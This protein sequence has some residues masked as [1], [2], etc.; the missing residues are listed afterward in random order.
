MLTLYRRALA[1]RRGSPALGRGRLHWVSPAEAADQVLSFDL[2]GGGATVR[3]VVNVGS[4]PVGLPVGEVLLASEATVA[5]TLPP[6]ATAWIQCGS[7][8]ATVPGGTARGS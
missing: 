8:S 5:G 3:V 1:V 4:D 7:G 6:A 2:Q